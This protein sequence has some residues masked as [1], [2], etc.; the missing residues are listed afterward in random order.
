MFVLFVWFVNRENYCLLRAKPGG[1]CSATVTGRSAL[2]DEAKPVGSSTAGAVGVTT[3]GA[4]LASATCGVSVGKVTLP[5]KGSGL[6]STGSCCAGGCCA[7]RI[8]SGDVGGCGLIV[9]SANLGAALLLATTNG[10][11]IAGGGVAAANVGVGGSDGIPNTAAGS[12][13]TATAGGGV[14]D[15]GGVTTASTG[16]G[17]LGASSIVIAGPDGRGL[18][19]AAIVGVSNVSV[20]SNGSLTTSPATCGVPLG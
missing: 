6:V 5:G 18:L 20:S 2:R 10:S 14:G 19:I 16:N 8:G 4:S 13:I 12:E 9:T 11:G 15:V 17:S 3:F 1:C 7:T